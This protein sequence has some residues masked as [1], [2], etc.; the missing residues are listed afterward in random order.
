MK[1]EKR[2]EEL[3]DC[4]RRDR[5]RIAGS[6]MKDIGILAAAARKETDGAASRVGEAK[7]E[8]VNGG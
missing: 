7:G 1:P 5:R 3:W 2:M 8:P 4:G 6:E